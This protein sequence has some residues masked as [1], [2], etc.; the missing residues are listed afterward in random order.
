VIIGFLIIAVLWLRPQGLLPERRDRDGEPR[1]PYAKRLVDT[2]RAA[3]R[4][5]HLGPAQQK[6]ETTGSAA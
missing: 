3:Q 6:A 5:L 1:E 2:A 4:V